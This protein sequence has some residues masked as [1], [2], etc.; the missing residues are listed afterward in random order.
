MTSPALHPFYRLVPDTNRMACLCDRLPCSSSVSYP[1]H[2]SWGE[3]RVSFLS[4]PWTQCGSLRVSGWAGHRDQPHMLIL[5]HL[6]TLAVLTCK[7]VLSCYFNLPCD[8]QCGGG[9]SVCEGTSS[10]SSRKPSCW[11]RACVWLS[12]SF[13]TTAW[14]MVLSP[15][16]D[17]HLHVCSVRPH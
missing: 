14:D 5:G 4:S 8:D 1:K 13:S 15:S 7:V 6:R 10:L 16:C 12:C 17:I 3:G 11:G 9:K 2:R